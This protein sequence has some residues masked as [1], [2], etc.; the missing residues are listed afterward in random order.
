MSQHG[1]EVNNDEDE[2]ASVFA[3]N[4]SVLDFLLKKIP[5][6]DSA[7]I[8]GKSGDLQK[9]AISESFEGE[10]DPTEEEYI[11]NLIKLR[12]RIAGFDKIRGGLK[13]TINVFKAGCIIVTS[14]DEKSI[15]AIT[16]KLT[17]LEKI[18]QILSQI[19]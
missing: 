8:I 7:M 12:Y 16:T 2:Y 4:K 3:N 10:I 19:K 9:I 14:I 1:N 18:C 5:E 6:I 11:A 13:M 17:N 15:L